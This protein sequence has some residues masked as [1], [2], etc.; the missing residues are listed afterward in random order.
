MHA[1]VERQ[2][3]AHRPHAL[4]FPKFTDRRR[5]LEARLEVT[6]ARER[7]AV[8]SVYLPQELGRL[9]I[10]IFN[11]ERMRAGDVA[12]L[13]VLHPRFSAL[14][15][16]LSSVVSLLDDRLKLLVSRAHAVMLADCSDPNRL[17]E[18]LPLLFDA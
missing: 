18:L 13:L 6:D 16:H 11:L 1:A 5:R 10:L 12:L 8:V 2:T 9:S 17:A 3:P 14:E 7:L 4:A 15:E